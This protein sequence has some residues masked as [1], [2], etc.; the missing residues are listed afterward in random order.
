MII[1]SDKYGESPQIFAKVCSS[2]VVLL[3]TGCGG[4]PNN[5]KDTLMNFLEMCPVADNDGVPINQHKKPYTV[6]STHCHYDHI[7]T[8]TLYHFKLNQ[9]TAIF[10]TVMLSLTMFV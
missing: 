4:N 3:D 2:T 5:G 6:I 10:H 9:S 1:E 8:C 7:G